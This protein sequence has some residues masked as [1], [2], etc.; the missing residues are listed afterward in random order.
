MSRRK[1]ILIVPFVAIIAVVIITVSI[2]GSQPKH[3]VN[4]QASDNETISNTT[5]PIANYTLP[6][7]TINNTTNQKTNETYYPER[8]LGSWSYYN[9][10]FPHPWTVDDFIYT[11][12]D[13]RK[14]I[15][16][17]FMVAGD[18]DG[19]DYYAKVWHEIYIET[20]IKLLVFWGNGPWQNHTS[21]DLFSARYKNMTIRYPLLPQEPSGIFIYDEPHPSQL[22]GTESQIG[23]VNL[24]TSLKERFPNSLQYANFLYASL[25]NITY[26]EIIGDSGIDYVSSDEYWDIPIINYRKTYQNNFYPNLQPHQKVLLVPYAAYWEDTPKGKV[27]N[28]GIADTFCKTNSPASADKYD[29]WMKNDT[30]IN[31]MIV[32]RLKNLWWDGLGPVLNNTGGTGLGLID[33]D[34]FGSYIMP[35]T[36]NYYQTLGLLYNKDINS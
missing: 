31:G 1:T 30:M 8:L 21:I 25:L 9:A 20:G 22:V 19:W 23:L 4:H 15:W 3:N 34:T 12:N 14:K 17:N 18:K 28:A 6:N 26:C 10:K 33:R 32:Y 13:G 5:L 36:V 11:D 7:N 35:K 16:Q 24:S 2:I 29:A 27:I